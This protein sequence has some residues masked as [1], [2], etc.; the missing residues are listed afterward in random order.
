MKFFENLFVFAGVVYVFVVVFVFVF[1]V[2]FVFVAFVFV[3][4]VV[5]K[6]FENLFVVFTLAVFIFAE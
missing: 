6:F 2:V 3:V 4:V 5:V 1:V